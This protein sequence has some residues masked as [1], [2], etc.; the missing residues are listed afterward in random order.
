M[1]FSDLDSLGDIRV[2]PD[3]LK[4]FR[5]IIPL[6]QRYAGFELRYVHGVFIQDNKISIRV[7]HYRTKVRCGQLFWILG[8]WTICTF[9]YSYEEQKWVLVKTEHGGI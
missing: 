5:K 2:I 3:N 6:K 7:T 8:N 4:A 9:E 1:D